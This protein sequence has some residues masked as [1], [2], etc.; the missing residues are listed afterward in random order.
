MT[1]SLSLSSPSPRHLSGAFAVLALVA[2]GLALV[3][4]AGLAVQLLGPGAPA[5][6]AAAT[7]GQSLRS[8]PAGS[9][10]LDPAIVGAFVLVG[11]GILADQLRAARTRS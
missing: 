1:R 11:I 9:G 2:T 4:A 3:A 6:S 7:A 5:A 10:P 8:G